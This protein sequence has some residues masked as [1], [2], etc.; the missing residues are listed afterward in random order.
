MAKLKLEDVRQEVELQEWKLVTDK[1]TNLDT[2]MEFNCPN[3]HKVYTTFKKWRKS[4]F[5]PTCSENEIKVDMSNP[6]PK[7]KGKI[8]VLA[9]DDATNITGWCIYDGEKLVSY[10]KFQIDKDNPIER[11]SIIRQWLLNM[12]TKWKPDKIGIED[13]QLQEFRGTNGK[14]NYAVTTYKVLAQ[15]QGVL[16]E[17]IFSQNIESIVVHSATW[18]SY[19]NISGKSRTDQKRSAQFKVK[20]WYGINVTQDEADAICIGKYLSGKYIKNNEMISWG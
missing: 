10:G 5:C 15:L 16:L 9:L 19:C 4:P 20:G 14:T 1:Y 12:I 2:E 17:S 3:G 11:I 7:E 6:V 8:R 18:K 13:I